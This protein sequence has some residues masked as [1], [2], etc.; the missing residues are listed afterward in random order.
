MSGRPTD[1]PN[2]PPTGI[3]PVSLDDLGRL[4]I[5]KNNELFWDGKRLVTSRRIS[6][7]VPQ[8]VLAV[9]AALA[10]LATVVTGVNNAAV[11]LCARDIHWLTCPAVIPR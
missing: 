9:L 5:N 10:S 11:F 4:G 7:T 6:L 1:P 3:Q 2:A 8:T